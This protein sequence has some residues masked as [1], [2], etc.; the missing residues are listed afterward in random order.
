MGGPPPRAGHRI[1][2]APAGLCQ[3]PAAPAGLRRWARGNV[4]KEAALGEAKEEP[5]LGVKAQDV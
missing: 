3:I 5:P 2:E 1:P 4:G